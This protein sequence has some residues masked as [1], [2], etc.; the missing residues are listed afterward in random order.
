[1]TPMSDSGVEYIRGVD[2]EIKCLKDEVAGLQEVANR[3]R[4]D[5]VL[6]S[7]L[8]GGDV[9]TLQHKLS[10]DLAAE[11]SKLRTES[12]KRFE[13]L[14]AQTK[15]WAGALG[16]EIVALKPR[17]DALEAANLERKEEIEKT[18]ERCL[19]LE[20]V[21]PTL[22][23]ET[24]AVDEK[25][26]TFI[27]AL[28]AQADADRETASSAVR[29]ASAKASQDFT[30]AEERIDALTHATEATKKA[31]TMD[32]S[33]ISTKLEGVEAFAYT[34]A[35]AADV[36][37]L[38]LRINETIEKNLRNINEELS[39]KEFC[40]TV[41]AVSDRV[42]TL[43]LDVNANEAK[44]KAGD[45]V[46]AKQI[47]GLEQNLAKTSRQMDA[48]RERSNEAWVAVEKEINT[49]AGRIDLDA[50][51]VRV[52]V[53]EAAIPPLAPSIATKADAQDV[54]QLA[55]R[56][57]A[58]EQVYPTKADASE[59]P[60]LHLM[61]ADYAAKHAGVVARAQEQHNR[62]ERADDVLRE[63]VTRLEGVE[64]KTKELQGTISTKAEIE[65]VYNKEACSLLFKD[66]YRREEI[67][68]MMTRVWWRVGDTTKTPRL[69][70]PWAP[71]L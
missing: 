3:L 9:S 1:L 18:G 2:K 4:A 29:T 20:K 27:A 70:S 52:S 54:K 69:P 32:I 67:D 36:Q 23:A 39:R 47:T 31:L 35:K 21:V 46:L 11:I 50:V 42:T 34:R 53:V 8:R 71:G 56:T 58:L 61:I 19:Q 24:S 26:T 49:K 66:F 30:R 10:S 7:K 41:K 22:R 51:A 62:L 68:A 28:K 37:A 55:A 33:G 16:Q 13:D 45:E 40:S 12:E 25:F 65:Q 15:K 60:K 5:I 48:D 43:L 64:G 14:E 63:H 6:E 17:L 59:L 38:E 44:A 57:L